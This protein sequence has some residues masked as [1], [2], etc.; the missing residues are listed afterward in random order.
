[1]EI[2]YILRR[3]EDDGYS[4]V[5]IHQVGFHHVYQDEKCVAQ[6]IYVGITLFHAAALLLIWFILRFTKSIIWS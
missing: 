6:I 2:V 3:I 5:K 4:L 1:M